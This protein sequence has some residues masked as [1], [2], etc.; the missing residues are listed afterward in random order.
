MRRCRLVHHPADALAGVLVDHLERR[1]VE[2]VEVDVVDLLL[3][4]LG[5][6]VEDGLHRALLEHQRH[7]LALQDLPKLLVAGFGDALDLLPLQGAE[8]A[9]LGAVLLLQERVVHPPGEDLHVD[10]RAAHA[11]GHAQRGVLHVLRLLAEDGGEE[12][13]LGGQLGLAL[14]RDLAH[15]DVAA[16]HPRADAHDA[17][18]VQVDE[19]LLGDVRDLAGDL[20]HAP[21]GVADVE[22]QLLDVDGREDVVLHQLLADDDGVLE[23]VAVPGH[24]RHED[25]AS[26]GELAVVRAGPVGDDVAG[27]HFLAR[28]DERTLVDGRVL[29]GA[30]ELLQPV[31]VEL[32]QLGQRLVAVWPGFTEPV[33]TTISSA[34]TW[35]HGAARGGR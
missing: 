17:A 15:Q 35:H 10:D 6:L 25:V 31:P 7:R 22:L 19:A 2:L 13:L 16:L 18:L 24:E 9:D 20:F 5:A 1:Q 12:L 28:P 14:R 29:V 27:L 30:P 3:G 34:V 8:R 4:E 32:G 11:R 33:S 21:L 26:Q 23:V